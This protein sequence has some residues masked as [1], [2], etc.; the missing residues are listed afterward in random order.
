MSEIKLVNLGKKVLSAFGT[1]GYLFLSIPKKDGI[2][3]K[4]PKSFYLNKQNRQERQSH[5]E[6]S[7]YSTAFVLRHYGNEISGLQAYDKM[8]F[9]I[10]FSGYVL[11]KSIV[12]CMN[13]YSFKCRIFKGNIETL[14]SRLAEGKPVI[15]EI[16][17]GSKWQHY[18]TLVGYDSDKKEMYFFDSAKE[19]RENA[20]HSGNRTMTEEEFLKVWDNGLPWFNHMYI[21][22]D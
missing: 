13:T 12:E 7:A 21:A 10:P 3:I 18:M 15:V 19:L 17:R 8:K 4:Y 9:K 6:C 20:N 16:G 22:I 5:N 14:K 11:P 1:L 2:D